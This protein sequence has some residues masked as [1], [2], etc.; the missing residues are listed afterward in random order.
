[1]FTVSD[2]VEL[3]VCE[4]FNGENEC[5]SRGNKAG[6]NIDIEDGKNMLTNKV[7]GCFTITEIEVWE[8]KFIH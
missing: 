4:P 5:E 7:D 2:T 1:M 3:G 8:V 6:Y